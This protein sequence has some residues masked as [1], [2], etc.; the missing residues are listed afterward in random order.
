MTVFG[1]NIHQLIIGTNTSSEFIPHLGNTHNY[2]TRKK[3]PSI[4]THKLKLLKK[5]I[6][7]MF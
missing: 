6:I 2:F 3:T 1:A 7:Y 4:T 5:K